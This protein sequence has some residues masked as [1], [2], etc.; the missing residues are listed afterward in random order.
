LRVLKAGGTGCAVLDD[1]ASLAH[2]ALGFLVRAA[3]DA[4]WPLRLIVFAL[5]VAYEVVEDRAYRST[6][7]AKCDLL[8][9]MLGWL[10]VE[11]VGL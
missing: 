9:F 2:V 4:L 10:A 5:F 11:A 6:G 3:P 1:A 7:R 8:E